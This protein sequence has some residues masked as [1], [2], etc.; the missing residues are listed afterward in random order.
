M[1][2]L[3][4]LAETVAVLDLYL[5][6]IA[7]RP[8]DLSDP[9]WQ[10][11]M[12]AAEPLDEAGIRAEAEEALRALLG[13]YEHGDTGT[14][15]A[16]RAVFDRCPSFSWAAHLRGASF[17]T[18]LL[19]LSARDHGRDTRDE[20]MALGDIRAEATAAGVDIRPLLREVAELSSTVNKYGMGS[21]RDLLLRAAD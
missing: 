1:A 4:D 20:I 19:H 17:R 2:E 18:R 21:M 10:D 13:H 5:K 11:K 16:V 15:A 3:E 12:R 7:E 9:G 6:P 14:R 8:V